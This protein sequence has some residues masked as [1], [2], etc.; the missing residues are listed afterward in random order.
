MAPAPDGKGAGPSICLQDV[1][2]FPIDD[3]LVL[4]RPETSGLYILSPSAKLIWDIL[5]TGL[6]FDELVREFASICQIPTEI[7]RKSV[8]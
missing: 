4:A 7:D 1:W 6:P 2:E 8:V 3:F 5:K